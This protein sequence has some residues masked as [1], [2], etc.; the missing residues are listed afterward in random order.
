MAV[1][2]HSQHSDAI[3]M[4]TVYEFIPVVRSCWL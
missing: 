4:Q 1:C 2:S 3:I